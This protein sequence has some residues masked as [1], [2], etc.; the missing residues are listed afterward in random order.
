MW[1]W[2]FR[3]GNSAATLGGLNGLLPFNDPHSGAGGLWGWTAEVR[4][5]ASVEN[6]FCNG[7]QSLGS[8]VRGYKCTPHPRCVCPGYR[9]GVGH[10]GCPFGERVDRRGGVGGSEGVVAGV[11]SPVRSAGLWG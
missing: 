6:A 9:G 3:T 10:P 11:H 2:L 1:A 7:I 4:G 5:I 8:V